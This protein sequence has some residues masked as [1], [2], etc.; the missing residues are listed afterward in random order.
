MPYR[1]KSWQE[2]SADKKDFPKILRLEKR[3]TCYN[4]FHKMG[5]EVGDEI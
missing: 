5:A 2:K 4:A 3:F 1:T